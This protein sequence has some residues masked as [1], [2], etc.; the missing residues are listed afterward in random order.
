MPRAM[1]AISIRSPW[2]WYILYAG[3]D[4]ENRG[5]RFPR[6]FRGRI[7]IHASKWWNWDEIVFDCESANHMWAQRPFRAE[8]APQLT[9]DFLKAR[10]G[11]VVGSVEIV[12][13]VTESSSPWFV[14][15]LGVVLKNP[16]PFGDPVPYKGALGIFSV[17]VSSAAMQSELRPLYAQVF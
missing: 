11:C 4:I 13:Y 12:D 7:L 2:W 3:K 17:D 15:D 16:V 5:L 8:A 6:W 9:G 14:G 10:G 1:K